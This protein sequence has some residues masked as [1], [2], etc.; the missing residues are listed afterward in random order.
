M[1][2]STSSILPNDPSVRR[3]LWFLGLFY[4]IA[5]VALPIAVHD[6][7]S[8]DIIEGFSWGNA[9]EAGYYKHPPLSPWLT[10]AFTHLFGKNLFAVFILSPLALI[11]AF[12]ALWVLSRQFFD[13]R[14]STVGLY[15]VSTQLYF[16]LLIPE[17]NHNVMQIPLWAAAFALFWIAVT[18][19][20]TWHFALLGVILGLCALAKYSAAI[21]YARL[22]VF[23][24][25]HPQARQRLS[26]RSV[27]LCAL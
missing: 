6:A 14:T 22:I 4:L 13:E 27:A 24:L 1:A 10:A 26:L 18:Q 17:F 3:A 8:L 9:W 25:L 2:A 23:A 15:L 12:V 19:G 21:L 11:G 7:P 16:S 5:W 20:K